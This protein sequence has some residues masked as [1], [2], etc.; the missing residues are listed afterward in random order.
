MAKG[1]AAADTLGH[2]CLCNGLLGT[3]GLG[4]FRDGTPE[5]PLLT[6]GDDL[7][8]LTR[9]LA[10]GADS[11]SAADVIAFLLGA[12]ESNAGGPTVDRAAN[13]DLTHPLGT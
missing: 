4:Q 7:A 12:V 11:Y 10:P 6:A 3:I 9:F 8:R 13:A 1:G 2:M 5:P